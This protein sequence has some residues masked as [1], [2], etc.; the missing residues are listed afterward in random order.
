MIIDIKYHI[1]SLVAVFLAL[2]IGV[3]IGSAVLGTNVNDIVMNQQ[4]Q[5]VDELN[6]K[7]DQIRKDNKAVQEEINHYK[8]ALDISKEFETKTLPILVANKLYG[9]QVAIIETTNYGIN[10]QWINTLKNSGAKV[11]S[12]TAV[13]EGFSL[14]NEETRKGIAAKLMLS[15]TSEAAVTKE[16]A[17]ELAVALTS[18]QNPEKLHY[19]EQLGLIKTSGEYGVPVNAVIFVGGS[20]IDMG[21][22]C[23]NFDLPMISYF[24]SKNIPVYGVEPSNVVFSYMKQ[25]QKLKMSTIDNIDMISGQVSLVMAVYGKPGNYGIKTSARQ[26][27]PAIP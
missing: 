23:A 2:G 4:K 3:L 15:N 20:Q 17:N 6:R 12:I 5:I 7:M 24:L 22:R 1:A 18:A 11:K 13:Q 10:D 19:F 27:M 25:Y 14:K 16:V 21:D 8:S 9:R 26:L